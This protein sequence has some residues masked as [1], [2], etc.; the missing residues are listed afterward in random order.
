[1]PRRKRKQIRAKAYIQDNRLCIL[2]LCD[3]STGPIPF[4]HVTACEGPD[5]PVD[6]GDD[7][8]ADNVRA[9]LTHSQDRIMKQ[10]QRKKMRLTAEAL[11]LR[12]RAGD[13][14][15]MSH[16]VMIREN[17]KRGSKRAML[18]Q[19]LIYE[20][21]QDNPLT[22]FG[23]EGT[24]QVVKKNRALVAFA[25]SVRAKDPQHTMT[26]L[27]V[28]APALNAQQIAVSLANGPSLVGTNNS[29]INQLIGS[30]KVDDGEKS[31]IQKSI[32]AWR[33]R[34]AHPIGRLL[35]LA[36]CIQAVRLPKIPIAILSPMAAWELGE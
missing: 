9:T 23:Q 17:A 22:D 26:A 24:P 1:M 28:W 15:A 12:A 25:K 36:R 35:G 3:S 34:Q 14:N 31:I 19:Q 27:E 16:I 13:Q 29:R 11:V 2:G 8:L 33:N 4:S 10:L 32:D 18:S 6:V 20:Y 30:M 7:D 5:G 21:L